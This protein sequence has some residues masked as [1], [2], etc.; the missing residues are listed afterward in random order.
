MTATSP[1]G[2]EPLTVPEYVWPEAIVMVTCCNPA[3]RLAGVTTVPCA[4]IT[5]PEPETVPAS[6]RTTEGPTWAIRRRKSAW[7]WSRP[8][9]GAGAGAGAT[10]PV[11]GGVGLVAWATSAGVA[12]RIGNVHA[13]R[14]ATAAPAEMAMPTHRRGPDLGGPTGKVTSGSLASV[15]Q[16]LARET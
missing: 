4:S 11:L 5:R 12:N 9:A 3:T 7:T 2:S 13:P 14:S 1:A 6:T 8:P 15:S 10:P 16:T